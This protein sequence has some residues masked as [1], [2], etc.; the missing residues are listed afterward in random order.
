M[1]NFAKLSNRSLLLLL[2][3]LVPTLLL[4]LLTGC[5]DG[6]GVLSAAGVAAAGSTPDA[7]AV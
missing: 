3:V 2:L 1:R 6:V 5:I 7:R 4:S